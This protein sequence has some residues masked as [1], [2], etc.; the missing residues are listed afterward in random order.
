[1]LCKGPTSS[2]YKKK[3]TFNDWEVE[4]LFQNVLTMARMAFLENRNVVPRKFS[5]GQDNSALQL[6]THW[7]IAMLGTD[8]HKSKDICSSL[9]PGRKATAQEEITK[10][11]NGNH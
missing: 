9:F 4:I 6:R 3:I 5:L 8:Y 7:R 11:Y 2:W 10:G 1:M